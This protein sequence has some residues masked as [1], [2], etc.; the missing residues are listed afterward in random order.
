M[1]IGDF[2]AEKLTNTELFDHPKLFIT[3]TADRVYEV[4]DP[5]KSTVATIEPNQKMMLEGSAQPDNKPQ[6]IGEQGYVIKG[7]EGELKLVVDMDDVTRIFAPS[8]TN[9]VK[10]VGVSHMMNDQFTLYQG[11]T[12]PSLVSFAILKRTHNNEFRVYDL[13]NTEVGILIQIDQHHNQVHAAFELDYG[14]VTSKLQR[15]ILLGAVLSVD[16]FF[17]MG[18]AGGSIATAPPGAT[19]ESAI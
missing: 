17:Y 15:S 10:Q 11:E 18:T 16:W 3:R 4:Q 6:A 13:E 9:K 14:G 7:H 8:A 19:Y 5:G 2:I 12:E 1:G